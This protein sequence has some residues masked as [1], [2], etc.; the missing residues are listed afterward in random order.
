MNWS[1]IFRARGPCASRTS[2]MLIEQLE[3]RSTPAFTFT[4]NGFGGGTFTPFENFGGQVQTASGDVNGD[5]TADII[6]AQ[7]TGAGSASRVRIFDG[8]A[9]NTGAQALLIADFFAYSNAAGASQTPGFSGGVF[10]AAADFNGDG[11]AEVVTSPGAG[12]SGHIKV[13]NFHD[14]TTGQ[15][16][17]SNPQLVT[18]FFAYPGFAGDV[19]VA[20]VNRAPGLTPLLVTASGAGTSASDIRVFDNAFTIG[21]AAPGTLVMPAAQTFV[22]PGFLGGVSIAGGGTATNPVLFVAPNTASPLVST[23]TFGT[24]GTGG[25]SLVPGATFATG[26]GNPPDIRLG[27]ADV[28][29][30]GVLDAL[31]SFPG[32]ASANVISTFTVIGGGAIPL[33][34]I[35]GLQGFGLFGNTWVAASSFASAPAAPTS[36]LALA[37][38]GGTSSAFGG[39]ASA[40]G[41]TSP[42]TMFTSGTASTVSPI[43]TAPSFTAT[44]FGGATGGTSNTG[45]LSPGVI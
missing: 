11:S 3:D 12:G 30:D 40:F 27:A 7:G 34:P 31:V 19:R 28:N 9:A 25:L 14:T 42:F 36:A 5:G 33:A 15:F 35:V 8:A 37:G 4:P 45:V 2:A 38:F 26:T 13:F 21:S 18:S 23:F 24:T 43:T 29:N 41:G 32:T 22:F 20:T 17:G 44:N 1:Q 6:V 16:L 39:T 10:V